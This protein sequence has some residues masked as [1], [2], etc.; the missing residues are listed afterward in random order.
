[1]T[2]HDD[3]VQAFDDWAEDRARGATVDVGVRLRRGGMS[4]DQWTL[5]DLLYEL[6]D[7]AHAL[8]E[9]VAIALGLPDGTTYAEAA[10]R[11]WAAMGIPPT[12]AA[13]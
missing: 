6:S 11:L 3:L 8:P 7:D 5:T 10:R 13:C 1:M 9:R 12:A 2:T 4:T